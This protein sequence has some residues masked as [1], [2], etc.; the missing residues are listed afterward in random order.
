MSGRQATPVRRDGSFDAFELSARAGE[1]E[2]S[3]DAAQ[4]PRF[5]DR[6]VAGDATAAVVSWRIAGTQDALGRPALVIALDGTVP[7][8]CQRCLEP[9]AWP[10]A[11]RTLLLLAKDERELARLDEDDEH[12]VVLA[13]APL[14]PRALV[15]DELLLTL[16][17]APR[18]ARPECVDAAPVAAT[19]KQTPFGALAGW[20]PAPKRGK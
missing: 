19:A 12:E 9:F 13:S 11:Q 3:V 4:L 14:D 5:A 8:E 20:K 17:F 18:C 15:E 6:L 10:V 7:L 2:G 1:I 16:P